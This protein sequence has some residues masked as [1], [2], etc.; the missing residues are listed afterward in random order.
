[1]ARTTCLIVLA[2]FVCATAAPAAGD[3]SV[4]FK[5]EEGRAAARAYAQALKK[6]EKDHAYAVKTARKQYAEGLEAALKA[7]M[8]RGDLDEAN[9]INDAKKR[10]EVGTLAGTLA[11]KAEPAA[12]V[13]MNGHA[14]PAIVGTWRYP[15]GTRITFHPNGTYAVSW[16]KGKPGR[17]KHVSGR[18]F[19][20]GDSA[21][22]L[23]PD[24]NSYP[25]PNPR[26]HTQIVRR[27]VVSDK[28]SAPL[29]PR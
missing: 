6:A 23:S 9:K 8:Q 17:W 7:A 19:T 26:A 3:A 1:M 20:I 16:R 5:Y 12:P 27:V 11:G 10:I 2:L 14:A 18:K 21:V 28:P 24:L 22:E 13:K 15:N 4:T 29:T 25:N